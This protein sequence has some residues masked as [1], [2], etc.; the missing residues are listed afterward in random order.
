MEDNLRHS[1]LAQI[2]TI[3]LK[4]NI[5]DRRKEE[6]LLGAAFGPDPAN[7]VLAGGQEHVL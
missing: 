6:R 3:L 4:I 1:F 5:P 7:T 2:G